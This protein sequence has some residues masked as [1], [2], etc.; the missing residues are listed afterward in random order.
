MAT[1]ENGYDRMYRE[2]DERGMRDYER[3][4]ER[5]DNPYSHAPAEAWHWAIGWDNA[6]AL[7]AQDKREPK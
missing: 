6:K 5:K 2:A 3:G 1:N 4:V 7:D